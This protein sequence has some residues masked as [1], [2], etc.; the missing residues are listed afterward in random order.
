MTAG[1]EEQLRAGSD[2]IT[3]AYLAAFGGTVVR[4]LPETEATRGQPGQRDP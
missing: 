2:R 4:P 3:A 1:D